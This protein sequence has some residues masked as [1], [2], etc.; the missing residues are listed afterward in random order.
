VDHVKTDQGICIAEFPDLP[1]FFARSDE[2][3]DGT[4]T[5][6][7][8]EP[9]DQ[10]RRDD[11]AEY[12]MAEKEEREKEDDERTAR[13]QKIEFEYEP[14]KD[15]DHDQDRQCFHQREEQFYPLYEDER[16]VKIEK[17]K[18]DRVNDQQNYER[19]PLISFDVI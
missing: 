11:H 13:D 15:I 19:R 8:E 2:K 16:V 9:A 7:A 10:P 17:I 3:T 1:E 12:E 6:V 4:S 14:R 5:R 18:D